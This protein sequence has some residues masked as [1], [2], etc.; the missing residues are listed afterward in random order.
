MP[1][2]SRD[3]YTA[4]ERKKYD[5]ASR[6]VWEKIWSVPPDAGKFRSALEAELESGF[7]IDW[8]DEKSGETLLLCAVDCSPACGAGHVQTLVCAGADVN[9]KDGKGRTPLGRACWNFIF[10]SNPDYLCAINALLTAGTRPELGGS[11]WKKGWS[12]PE[13]RARCGWLEAYIAS[14]PERRAA[15]DRSEAAAPAFDYAL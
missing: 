8:R 4:E 11:W 9:A 10:S 1:K 15:Q 3:E 6:R 2:I 7:P 5:G 13:E 14:W 12:E